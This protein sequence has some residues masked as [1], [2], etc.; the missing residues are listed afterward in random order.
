[1]Q[2]SL[3]ALAHALVLVLP[4]SGCASGQTANPP[5]KAERPV[6][7]AAFSTSEAKLL[8]CLDLRD[9]IVDLYASQYMTQQGLVLSAAEKAAFRNGWAEELAKK[10]TFERFERSCFNG[11]TPKKYRC[12]MQ[13]TTPGGIV[14][15]MKLI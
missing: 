1:M 12:G 8:A 2:F 3:R 15:C 11:L 9:H 14:A 5:Q 4:L 7:D 6:V 10:G 13:S